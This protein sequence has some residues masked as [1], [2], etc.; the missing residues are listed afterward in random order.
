MPAEPSFTPSLLLFFFSLAFVFAYGIPIP[1]LPSRQHVLRFPFGANT[2][3][4]QR[5][6]GPG[7]EPVD[8]DGDVCAGIISGIKSSF[9]ARAQR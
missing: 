5:D 3:W 2:C 8:S 4:C 9:E 6:E 1:C 7:G